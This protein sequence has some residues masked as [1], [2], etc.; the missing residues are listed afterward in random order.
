MKKLLLIILTVF[1]QISAFAETKDIPTEIRSDV[2][3]EF[4]EAIAPEILKAQQNLAEVKR[5]FQNG[6]KNAD[7]LYLTIRI[8]DQYGHVEQVYVKAFLWRDATIM[9]QIA[10]NL[11]SVSGYRRGQSISFDEGDI[12]DWTL[13]DS[14]GKEYGN[15]LGRYAKKW[16]QERQINDIK[17]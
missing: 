13:I 6:L 7:T 3:N 12:L 4:E 14:S 11:Y 17:H 5:R 15:Y 9:G 1:L 8:A 2:S 10:N 16:L